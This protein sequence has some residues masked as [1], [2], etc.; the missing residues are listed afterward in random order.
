[1]RKV[2]LFIAMSLDGYIADS[3]GGVGWLNG[4]DSDSENLDVY[5]E[6]VKEI[7]TILMG[8]NTYYQI[9]TELS[10]TEWVYSDFTTYVIT[11]NE[12]KATDEIRFTNENPIDLLTKLKSE[13]GKNIWICGGANLVQQVIRSD[14]IDQY[15]ISVIPTLLGSG[16]RLF[17]SMEKEIKLKLLRTQTYNGIT[18]LVYTHR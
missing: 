13:T 8:W 1:M 5:S 16:I 11:H 9:V 10:P 2:I 12:G 3:N 14:L 17:G 4:Q 6:F 7:D 18:D 15:Y